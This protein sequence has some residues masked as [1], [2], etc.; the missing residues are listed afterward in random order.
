MNPPRERQ[1]RAL[2]YPE[3]ISGLLALLVI[4]WEACFSGLATG[5]SELQMFLRGT[6]PLLCAVVWFN[7]LTVLLHFITKLLHRE[8]PGRFLWWQ[9]VVGLAASFVFYGGIWRVLPGVFFRISIVLSFVIGMFSLVTIGALVRE[10]RRRGRPNTRSEWSP[11]VLFFTW[12]MAFVLISTLLLLTP[13]ATRVPISFTE[14]FFTCASAISFL[15]PHYIVRDKVKAK[16][17]IAWIHT[18]YSTVVVNAQREL[19][20]WTSYDKIVSISADVTKAFLG[21]FPSLKEKIIEIDNPLPINLIR[22]QGEEFDAIPEMRG[23]IKLL[24]IGR[25]GT[26]KNF[27]GAVAIMAELCKLRDDVTWYV[28]GYGGGEQEIR[29]AI[30]KY[31]MQDKFILLG[32]KSNPYPYI[33]ACDVYVQPSIYEGKSITVKEAQLLSKPVAI[34]NYPTAHSQVNHEVDG[35]IL[36]L[37]EPVETAVALHRFLEDKNLIHQ[38]SRLEYNNNAELSQLLN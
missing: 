16:K 9:L 7:T 11:A 35:V 18:D 12:M 21:V 30:A 10:R 26:P 32:K 37:G 29:D 4:G 3:I 33:K 20:V 5:P 2:E 6:H 19:S 27:P 1:Y 14:A 17:K 24:S 23:K 22:K 8:S 31:N 13:G 15:T 25:Y 38:L 36:P 28:I 34:T